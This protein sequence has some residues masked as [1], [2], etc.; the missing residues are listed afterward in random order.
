MVQLNSQGLYK[1]AHISGY[2]PGSLRQNKT[3]NIGANT[4]ENIN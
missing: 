3:K 4:D 2:L 1:A